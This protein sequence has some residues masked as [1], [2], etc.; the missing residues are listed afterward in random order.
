MNTDKIELHGE[1]SSELAGL[2][3]D[4][5][6]AKLFPEYS[7]SLLQSWIRDGYVTVDEKI[8]QKPR[9]KVSADQKITVCAT[10]KPDQRWEAQVIP[11]NVVYEDDALLVI[12]KPSGLVVHP[13]AGT[14]NNTLAN[15]LLH[16]APELAKVPRSGIIHR[17]DKDTSGLLVIARTVTAH[18]ALTQQM[19]ERQIKRE[20]E[21]IVKG[22]MISGGQVDVEID[23]HPTQPDTHGCSSWRTRSY[24]TLSRHRTLS[25]SHPYSR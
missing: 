18:H 19:K 10:L 4:Q 22:V 8:S 1:I 25:Q 15:A 9:E 16:H 21:A 24:Y 2:R 12:N 14:P 20:Y 13:G 5:A 17:L 7:R 11:L 6:L 23:R 3:L